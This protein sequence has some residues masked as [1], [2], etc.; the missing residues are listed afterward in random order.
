MSTAPIYH[1]FVQRMA[2]AAGDLVRRLPE[3]GLVRRVLRRSPWKPA[4]RP[5][6]DDLARFISAFAEAR[7]SA[8]FVQIGANDGEQVDYLRDAIAS[9][10]WRGVMVEPVPYLFE[11]LQ[12]RHGGSPRIALDNVAIADTEGTRTF[13]YLPETDDPSLPSWYHGLGSFRRDVVVT[14]VGFIPDIEARVAELEVPCLSFDTLCARHGL[15]SIDLLQT[16]TE[17]YD[18][19][20]LEHVDL[21]RY[22]PTVVLFEHYHLEPAERR[23]CLDRFA[24]HGYEALSNGMDTLCLRTDGVR[25]GERKLARLW[26]R[27]RA[28]PQ[29]PQPA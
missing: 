20:L 10:G 26:R 6:V 29:A 8:T 7:P 19:E 11:R 1:D 13:Y 4:P 15:A 22:R 27:L 21:D 12:E 23:A 18:A 3:D 9:S 28:A 16:D 25:P 17:G 5:F 2:G 24:R 14:H